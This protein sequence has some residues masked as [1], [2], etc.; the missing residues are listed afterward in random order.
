MREGLVD[1]GIFLEESV[2]AGSRIVEY[3]RTRVTRAED[4]RRANI[5]LTDVYRTSIEGTDT[6]IDA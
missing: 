1:V 4:V 5:G 2:T 3:I 6:V